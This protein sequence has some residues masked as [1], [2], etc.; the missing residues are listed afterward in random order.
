MSARR[1]AVTFPVLTLVLG[2]AIPVLH[3]QATTATVKGR[4]VDTDGAGLPGVVVL[5]KSRNQPSGNKQ[6]VTDIEGNYRIP[7]LPPANDYTLRVDYPGFAP[8]E[9]GPLDLDSGKTVVQD[10]TLRSDAET[11]ETIVVESKGNIVDT[12]STK[13]STSY[14]AE[15][16]EGLP[17]IGRNYQDILTLAPGVTDTDGDGNPNVHGSRETGM[18]YRLDGGNITDP[19]NG[20]FGANLNADMIEEVEVITSGASAEY[21]RA[22]GGFA[23]I[24]T[25]SGGNDF[26]G[27]FTILWRG[28]FLNGEGANN[29]DTN[30]FSSS[31]PNY[32]DLRPTLTLGGAIVKDKLWYFGTAQ[33]LDIERPVNQIGSNVLVTARGNNSFGKLTWQVNSYNKLAFQVS[34]DPLTFLGLNL[35]LGVSPD[36]DFE[37]AQGSITPQLKWT[38][39]ISPQ[40]LLESTISAYNGRIKVTA[41]SDAFRPTE[42]T[43]IQTAANVVQADYPCVID[44]CNP[45]RGSNEVYQADLITGQVT[46]P[47]FLKY[48]ETGIRNSI[49]TDLSYTIE[50]AFGQHSIKS[51]IEFADEKF[52]DEE[53]QN[54]LLI[55]VT[56]PFE[57]TQQ[58]DTGGGTSASDKVSG[59]QLL[60][61]ASPL[62][63]PQR[64]SS[65][66]SGAYVYDAWKPLPNLTVNVGLR[67]DREDIDSSG[68]EFFDPRKERTEAIGLWKQIC[69]LVDAQDAGGT[70]TNCHEFN[71]EPFKY[72]GLPPDHFGRFSV[73]GPDVPEAVR[74]LDLD[75]DGFVNQSGEEGTAMHKSFTRF[76]ER[77][78]SNFEIVNNNLAPRFSV[79]WDPWADGKTKVFGNWSRFYD[80][81]FL[82]T[83]SQE[84][85]PDFVNY[86]FFPSPTTNVITDQSVSAAA[87][88]VSITQTDRNIRTPF[89]DE[90]TI[91]FER[92]LA[93]EWSVGLTYINKKGYDLLQDT[94]FNHITCPQWEELGIA[95]EFICGDGFGTPLELDRFGSSAVLGQVA[96]ST[97]GG[98]TGGNFGF[99]PGSGFLA[100]NGAPD[101]YTVNNNFNEVLRVGNFNSSRYEAY[102]LKITK[103]LHRNWQM[104]A[105]Y[106]WS[107]AYG[108]A[109][110]FLA[111]LGNDPQTV[112]D[113]EGYLSYDQRHILKFQAVTRLP[114]E[115]SLGSVIQWSSGTPWSVVHTIV[116]LDS[117]G[118][119]IFRTFYPSSQRNDQRNEGFWKIDTRIEKNFVLGKVQA[120]AFLSVENILD[121]DYLNLTE[122]DL[123]SFDGIG[124]EGTRD[125]GR[126]FE[127]G[128]TFKF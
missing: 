61:V 28:K 9:V 52:N 79:S 65:F 21:G 45:A 24:I 25:K 67:L 93:P 103:R 20:T 98:V 77:Q 41:V 42:I 87:S 37:F 8:L 86:S 30:K 58:G 100:R 48:S 63:T 27:R 76:F 94:D 18:Q 23:N 33:I 97:P 54:P 113:E 123:T 127:I 40:L 60:T 96:S 22:D 5:I 109:E 72:N 74:A 90:F 10:M 59:F 117:T 66:N 89:T 57:T 126:R 62:V 99:D 85:G 110:D 35:A 80:R 32:H 91:G 119:Q 7:L 95:P 71:S 36:S 84:I 106:T 105:S 88:T 55:D 112:D 116:D 114:K 92:E 44:N 102:E 120:S 39:T 29:N 51:G 69:S 122:Y 73:T 49:K 83:I 50:D 121:E 3:A 13:T 78:T 107:E 56:K 104:L 115:I 68:F 31:F 2:L 46:G 47:Y 6:V 125:I 64:A 101:L 43:R 11:T 26:E 19:I 108:Q 1:F 15:F 70:T 128:S 4:V 75:G 16:I 17:I 82:A 111:G 53:L 14:N 118:N 38:S 124:L 34:S 81:L 12:E